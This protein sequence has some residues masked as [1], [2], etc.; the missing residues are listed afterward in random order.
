MFEKGLFPR[1]LDMG[2][3]VYGHTH[4]GYW[5]DMGTPQKYF[6]LNMDLLL[7]KT[8]S[9]LVKVAGPKLVDRSCKIGLGVALKG[10][11][12]IGKGCIIRDGAYLENAILWDNISIGRNSQIS[13]C[14]IGSNT[15]IADNSK[16]KNSV[17]TP[18]STVLLS[19]Q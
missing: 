12:I 2:Q 19:V 6:S 7:K 11:V 10:P 4:K 18:S 14:I 3:P 17:I 5:L 9:P 16:I 8:R 13:E 1:L 15:V